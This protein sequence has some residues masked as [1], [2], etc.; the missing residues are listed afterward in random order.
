MHNAPSLHVL[1][2]KFTIFIQAESPRNVHIHV[3]VQLAKM[4]LRHPLS[5]N[6]RKK[7]RS[8]LDILSDLDTGRTGSGKWISWELTLDEPYQDIKR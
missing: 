7:C 8:W 3:E 4:M 6:S 5:Y 1:H 2:Y